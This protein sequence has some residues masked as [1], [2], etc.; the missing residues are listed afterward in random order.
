MF[1]LATTVFAD[2]LLLD[3][4]LLGLKKEDHLI[5]PPNFTQ[6]FS[7][8]PIFC[9]AYQAHLSSV[10]I[11]RRIEKPKQFPYISA[12][13]LFICFTL[14]NVTGIF[15]MATF[16]RVVDPEMLNSYPLTDVP[17][18]FARIGIIGCVSGAYPVFT[19]TG[20]ELLH[21]SDD[22]KYR[23]I[24][25]C[26]WY[27]IT[28]VGALYLPDFDLASKIIGSMAALLIFVIPG[29]ALIIA[30]VERKLYRA[31]LGTFF[32]TFGVFL[33]FYSLLTAFM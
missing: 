6:L 32:A 13:A 10:K 4:E 8:F 16:G 19:I 25:A 22:I 17:M 23:Y 31:I 24:F 7:T 21:K 9:F 12:L 11:Y 33:F 27:V 14:Y 2:Y 28:L 20:R 3:D 30:Y 5:P 26:I 15:G 29:L 1:V 18:Y